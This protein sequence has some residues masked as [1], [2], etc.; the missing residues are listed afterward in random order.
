MELSE[1]ASF[2]VE[3]LGQRQGQLLGHPYLFRNIS[4]EWQGTGLHVIMGRSGAGKSTLL[5]TLGGVWRPQEGKLFFGGRGLW[6]RYSPIQDPQILKQIGFLFQNNALFS[7]VS[8]LENLCLPHRE[9]YVEIG[10]N[11]RRE[12]AMHFLE[13]VGLSHA[14]QQ[15]PHELSG[16]MQKRLGLA[17]ALILKPRYIFLDDPTAGLDPITSHQMADLLDSLLK[18]QK[19]MVIIVTNDP[20]MARRW[21]PNIHI[22]E[23]AKLYSPQMNNYSQFYEPYFS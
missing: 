1:S 13:K 12:L 6:G 7:S 15:Q 23:D 9:K 5:K 22:L 16:G 3:N 10:E 17:R 4:F 8:V 18:E 19:G 14:A 11:E 2:R 20:Y 21:G